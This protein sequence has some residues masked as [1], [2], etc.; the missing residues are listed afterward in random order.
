MCNFISFIKTHFGN[1]VAGLKWFV[2]ACLSDQG[3]ISFGR[4][5]SAFW[6]LYFAVQDYHLF[7]ISRHLVD[8]ATLMS[9]LTVITTSYAITKAAQAFSKDK[10][11]DQK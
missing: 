11:P 6:T 4:T 10:E 3:A 7:I 5:L 9:Q 2:T 1:A 8:N